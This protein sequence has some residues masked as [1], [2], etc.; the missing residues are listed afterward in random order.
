MMLTPAYRLVIGD[1]KVDTTDEPR[2][3]TLERLVVQLDLDAPADSVDFRFGNVDGLKPEPDDDATVDLGYAEQP[4]L[5]LV[6]TGGV[7]S[8]EPGLISTSVLAISPAQK[9]LEHRVDETFLNMTAGD[10]ARK[11][12]ED[13]GLTVTRAD[14]GTTFPAYVVDGRRPVYTHLRDL[15]DLCGFVVLVN[16]NGELV[17]R[18]IDQPAAIH[19]F[20]FAKHIVELEVQRG[21]PEA[22]SVDVRGES[23]GTS[24]GEESWAWLTKDSSGARGTAGSGAPVKLVERP[25]LRTADATQR[26]A[27]AAFASLTSRATRGRLRTFGRPEIRLG[28]SI[29]VKGVPDDRLNGDFH[30][31]AV[32]HSIDKRTGFRTEVEFLG[33]G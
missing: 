28:D 5:T 32:R 11:L 3:S 29:R 6:F 26:A 18:P 12:A 24:R 14:P 27:D 2:A 33:I 23:P 30:V 15:A 4:S 22:A 20:E 9:L 17:F 10:I 8:V 1:R 31:R 21:D 16:E 13:A 7:A 25:V 19:V